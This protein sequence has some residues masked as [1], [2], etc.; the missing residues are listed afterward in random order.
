M[1]QAALIFIICLPVVANASDLQTDI[2]DAYSSLGEI[3]AVSDDLRANYQP[4]AAGSVRDAET[5]LSTILKGLPYVDAVK[6]YPAKGEP[7]RRIV[8]LANWHVVDADLLT[9]DLE[10]QLGRK[11]T[12]REQ[13]LY[14]WRHLAEVE[15][16]QARRVL[17]RRWLR[18]AVCLCGRKTGV[19]KR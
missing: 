3:L 10:D 15:T 5:D 2:I 13:L 11:L 14:H 16:V 12:R 19:R 7:K 18:G 9:A 6:F 4:K 1:K 17:C 8:H